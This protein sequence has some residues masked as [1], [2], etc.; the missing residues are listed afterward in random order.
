M[1]DCLRRGVV[2]DLQRLAVRKNESGE[3]RFTVLVKR[4]GHTCKDVTGSLERG[5]YV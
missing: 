3:E 4:W 5:R 2:D 1:G